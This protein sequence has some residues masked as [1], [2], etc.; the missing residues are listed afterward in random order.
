VK[1][2]DVDYAA[3]KIRTLCARLVNESPDSEQAAVYCAELKAATRELMAEQEAWNRTSEPDIHQDEARQSYRSRESDS[4]DG[5]AEGLKLFNP[6]KP[7][8]PKKKD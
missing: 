8:S 5:F 1:I 7:D 3:D 4:A 2:V 6:K